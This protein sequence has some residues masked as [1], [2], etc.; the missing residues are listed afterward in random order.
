MSGVPGG[1]MCTFGTIPLA[2]L[3]WASCQ[4][5]SSAPKVFERKHIW[6]REAGPIFSWR[7]AFHCECYC[8]F[9]ITCQGAQPLIE[10][11]LAK[12][13]PWTGVGHVL[14]SEAI[15]CWWERRM[16]KGW[17]LVTCKDIITILSSPSV[18]TKQLTSCL[19]SNLWPLRARYSSLPGMHCT[20]RED[21]TPTVTGTAGDIV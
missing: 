3:F 14:R 2:L 19:T 4:A 13:N 18:S 12:E 8:M 15:W 11:C 16:D 5:Q 21:E 20:V 1:L 10:D 9:V 6:F 17:Y 7:A